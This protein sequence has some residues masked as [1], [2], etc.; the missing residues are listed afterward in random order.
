MHPVRPPRHSPAASQRVRTRRVRR[1]LARVEAVKRVLEAIRITS[2]TS[3]ETAAGRVGWSCVDGRCRVCVGAALVREGGVGL[4]VHLQ[5]LRAMDETAKR[6]S[7][8]ERGE[9]R[10]P[11]IDA[12]H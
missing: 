2:S 8:A 4:G 12:T 7:S 6:L 11:E 9:R 3:T 5:S 1:P 10:V